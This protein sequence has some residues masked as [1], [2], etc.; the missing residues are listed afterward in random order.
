MTCHLGHSKSMKSPDFASHYF[1]FSFHSG[2]YEGSKQVN[3]TDDSSWTESGPLTVCINKTLL[4]HC[5][6]FLLDAVYGYLPVSSAVSGSLN[7]L[8]FI[9]T[10]CQPLFEV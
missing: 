8:L 3:Y 9:G 4:G 6:L 1:L 2:K 5:V 7:Y 10:S